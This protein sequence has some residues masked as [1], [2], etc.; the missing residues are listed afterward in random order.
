MSAG[1]Q[2]EGRQPGRS[3]LFL[4]RL[5]VGEEGD[6]ER[7]WRGKVQRAVTG[8]AHYFRDWPELA[9]LLLTMLRGKRSAIAEGERSAIAEGER[10]VIAAGER[11]AQNRQ[12]EAEA[13]PGAEASPEV[14]P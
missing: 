4:V 5:W 10:S 7:E 11:S 6:G 1:R 8:E 9:D 2:P 3:D 12:A 13:E 14:R